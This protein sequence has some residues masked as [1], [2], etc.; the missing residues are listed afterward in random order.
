MKRLMFLTVIALAGT[1]PV[2]AQEHVVFQP[3]PATFDKVELFIE[4]PEGEGARPAILFIHGHQSRERNGGRG[5]VKVGRLKRTARRG[6]VAAAVS[7]PGYGRSSGPPDF[8]GP[9]TQA[10]V[11]AAIALLRRDPG[12]DPRRV[13]LYGLSRGA[14]VAAMVAARDP[15]LK[16]VVLVAGIY[17]LKRA[18]PTGL[19]G[20]DVNIKREAGLTDAAFAARSALRHASRIKAATLILH[21]GEDDRAPA[22]HAVELGRKL[23]ANGTVVRWRIY[24]AAGH[25][26]PFPVQ[27]REIYPF[28]ERHLN[29]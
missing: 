10:A 5:F 27:Y 21:G 26:V 19:H 28:F 20:L 17:D 16:A 29:P 23:W 2:L 15:D 8:C 22:A 18:Y 4:R 3:D 9:K 13:A 1:C 24:E 14:I 6:Y 25:L 11:E 12:V 7:Q